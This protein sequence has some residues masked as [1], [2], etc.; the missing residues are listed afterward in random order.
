LVDKTTVLR[1]LAGAWQ[2]EQTGGHFPGDALDKFTSSP[3]IVY[4]T[5]VNGLH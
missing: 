5:M 4:A 2:D 1:L 3:C